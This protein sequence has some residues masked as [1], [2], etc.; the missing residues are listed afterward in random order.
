LFGRFGRTRLQT[1][2]AAQSPARVMS[3]LFIEDVCRFE[4]VVR[5]MRA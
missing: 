5:A 3:P 2:I 4:H 1:L